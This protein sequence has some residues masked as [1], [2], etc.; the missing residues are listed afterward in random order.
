ML[1]HFV[2][3]GADRTAARHVKPLLQLYMHQEAL[4]QLLPGVHIVA[5]RRLVRFD[6]FKMVLENLVNQA[7]FVLEIV[8]ELALAGSRGFDDL[9]RA[10]KVYPLLMKQ[11]GGR[12]DNSKPGV[13][14]GSI[15]SFHGDPLQ[16]VPRGTT[17]NCISTG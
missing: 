7:L 5:D 9:V 3:N 15:V 14:S 6:H 10:G 2:S 13:S 16:L 12:L 11:V 8:I 17:D 1:S 4:F